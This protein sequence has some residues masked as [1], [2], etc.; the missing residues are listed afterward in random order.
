MI[1]EKVICDYLSNKLNIPVLPEKPKRPYG[2]MVFVEKIGGG[3]G[4][5]KNSTLAIQSYEESLYK[6]AELNELVKDAMRDII[7]L[8]EICR[9][10]LNSDYNWTDTETKEYRYQA[11]YDIIH[12]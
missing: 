5:I 6:A 10:D 9:V 12:Y 8:N 3:D 1:I 4:F 2:R 7:E 11:V